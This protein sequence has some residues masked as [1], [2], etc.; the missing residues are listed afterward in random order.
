M[1][2]AKQWRVILTDRIL[3]LWKVIAAATIFIFCCDDCEVNSRNTA[4][5]LQSNSPGMSVYM[6]LIDQRS[7]L[8]D[9]AVLRQKLNRVQHFCRTTLRCFARAL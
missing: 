8:P 2:I 7:T 3:Q 4:Y 1:L 5:M 6:Y 9:D